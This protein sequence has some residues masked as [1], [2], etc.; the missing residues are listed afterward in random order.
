MTERGGWSRSLRRWRH[1]Q[2]KTQREM[3]AEIGITCRS[4]QR[5]EQGVIVPRPGS[6]LERTLRQLLARDGYEVVLDV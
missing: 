2:G 4:Y 1:R 5:Y 6:L 3:A